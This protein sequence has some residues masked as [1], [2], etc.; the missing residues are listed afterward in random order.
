MR[1]RGECWGGAKSYD[2]E[3]TLSSIN[4]SILSALTEQ[5]QILKDAEYTHFW[6][7]PHHSPNLPFT[8]VY[9]LMCL[10]PAVLFVLLVE[11]NELFYYVL[12]RC[13]P[14]PKPK[15]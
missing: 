15:Q 4:H 12:Y 11:I 9:T 14:P 8:D 2:S 1:G 13:P 10:F 6:P 5:G 7:P 3:E